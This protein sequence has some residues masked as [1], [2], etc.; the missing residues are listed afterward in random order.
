MDDDYYD[1]DGA[2]VPVGEIVMVALSSALQV[3][4]KRHICTTG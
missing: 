4:M 1:D 2:V 3:L